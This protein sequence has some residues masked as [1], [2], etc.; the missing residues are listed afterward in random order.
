MAQVTNHGGRHAEQ[1]RHFFHA[2]LARC[3][4]LGI[5][6]A[7]AHRLKVHAT[8]K[9]G[10]APCIARA[11]VLAAPRFFDSLALVSL[12]HAGELEHPQ[13]LGTIAERVHPMLTLG[14]R[15]L[16]HAPCGS[17]RAHTQHAVI[18][19]AVAQVQHLMGQQAV[20]HVVAVRVVIGQL[21]SSAQHRHAVRGQG[22]QF[23]H[24][25]I[26]PAHDA[27]ISIAAQQHTRLQILT[28]FQCCLLRVCHVV[29]D[30]IQ[31]VV[32]CPLPVF[33]SALEK[34][35]GKAGSGLCDGLHTGVNSAHALCGFLIDGA[36]SQTCEV[37]PIGV[38][39]CNTTTAFKS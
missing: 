34:N 22:P 6:K 39:T 2:E 28:G 19:Q 37:T 5:L 32:G 12:E 21:A 26:K 9:N 14:N 17:D 29:Q 27:C 8:F 31:R 36:T 18:T 20:Q 38:T 10:R 33:T 30:G 11:C 24:L 13:Q 23:A 4:P 25:A 7:H 15:Q 16:Y 35:Q 3:D 1:P